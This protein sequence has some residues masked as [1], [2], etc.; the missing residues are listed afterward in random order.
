MDNTIVTMTPLP[1]KRGLT[2]IKAPPKYLACAAE[3][4]DDAQRLPAAD[5]RKVVESSDHHDI[6]PPA[7]NKKPSQAPKG[8][9]KK[10][11]VAV[12]F[13]DW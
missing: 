7:V 13:G 4:E 5:E 10:K 2:L 11:D 6:A 12:P 1:E 3:P 8:A 9:L